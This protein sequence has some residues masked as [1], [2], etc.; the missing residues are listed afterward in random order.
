M[1]YFPLIRYRFYVVFWVGFF[2]L[3][4]CAIRGWEKFEAE[5][6]SEFS[7]F[8]TESLSGLSLFCFGFISVLRL[9]YVEF[10]S[11]F[12]LFGVESLLVLSLFYVEYHSE[13]S[14]FDVESIRDWVL[15]GLS[16]FRIVFIRGWAP[17]GF[18]PI[19]GWVHSDK[20]PIPGSIIPGSV[21][22]SS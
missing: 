1:R 2:Y 3:H 8:G 7:P 22:E 17:S 21:G 9:F 14:P 16:L 12:S 19:R 6:H 15:S 10:H 5:S 20:S 11:E 4:S 13:F 18:S